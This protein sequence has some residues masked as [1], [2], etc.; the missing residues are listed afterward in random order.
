MVCFRTKNTNFG[1]V[2]R[3]LEWKMLLYLMTIRYTLHT[4]GLLVWFVIIWYIF[5]FWY[6][7][8]KKN[9]AT[10]FPRLIRTS[11]FTENLFLRTRLPLFFYLLVFPAP[12]RVARWFVFKPKI[13]IWVNF[14]G[15]CNGRGWYILW[16]LIPFYGLLLYFMDILV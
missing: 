16:T 11:V 14:A 12:V 3:A 13:Q 1:K 4:Y 2:W 5:T 8:T 15:S 7:L 10:L 6:V 9:L